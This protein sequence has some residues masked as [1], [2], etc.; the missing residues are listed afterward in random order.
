MVVYHCNVVKSANSEQFFKKKNVQN[1]T[2]KKFFAAYYEKQQSDS[3][4]GQSSEEEYHCYILKSADFEQFYW[5][6]SIHNAIMP[7]ASCNFNVILFN[8]VLMHILIICRRNYEYSNSNQLKFTHLSIH[9]FCSAF[10][11]NTI[12]TCR[13]T[14]LSNAKS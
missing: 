1:T 7:Y 9:L 8:N 6:L 4:L 12:T 3:S 11:H 13:A 14:S 2:R 10:L 5:V